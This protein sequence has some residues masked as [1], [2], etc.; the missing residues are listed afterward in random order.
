[1]VT[2]A[3]FAAFQQQL[4]P[5][6]Y[7]CNAAGERAEVN[8]TISGMMDM[9]N[10]INTAARP[11]ET[12]RIESVTSSQEI[13]KATTKRRVQELHVGLA[14]VDAGVVKSRRENACHRR[15]QLQVGQ[16]CD[17]V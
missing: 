15:R 14:P 11:A 5:G 8:D 7:G 2:L 16:Q 10:S 12:S 17:R 6:S 13:G 1:M 9:L 4:R 3:D